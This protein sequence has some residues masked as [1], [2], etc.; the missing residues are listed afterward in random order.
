MLDGCHLLR[1]HGRWS[2]DG[3]R[4]IVQ[5]WGNGILYVL[6]VVLLLA[7][8]TNSPVLDRAAQWII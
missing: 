8:F 1:I 6:E 3:W 4:G 5:Y 2:F 7:R